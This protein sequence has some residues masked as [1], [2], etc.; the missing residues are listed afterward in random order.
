LGDLGF[1][2]PKITWCNGRGGRDFTKEMLDRAVAN[3]EW[4][5]IFTVVEVAVLA[6]SC[7]D[8]NPLLVSF[9]HT[10]D[11]V[12]QKNKIFRYEAAWSK[13]PEQK[14][15]IKKVWRPKNDNENSWMNIQGNLKG[16]RKSLKKW[17]WRQKI[18]VEL[19]IEA[20]MKEL[21]SIHMSDKSDVLVEENR[22]KEELHVMLEQEEHKWKQ[23]AKINWLQNGDRNTK[24]FNA[25]ANQRKKRNQISK[26]IDKDGRLCSSK[27]DIEEA[28]ISFRKELFTASQQREVKAYT[29]SLDQ[30]VSPQPKIVV[31]LYSRGDLSSFVSNVTSE[32]SRAR[33]ILS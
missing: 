3:A 6:N 33:R 5:S 16:C 12:W 1:V 31:L 4:C 27:E 14:E 8:R 10:N 15:I 26:I 11:V 28:F 23:R 13:H 32:G 29:I 24:F 21:L 2:G 17:V 30:K 22:I 19:Q 18:P 9:S 20:K 7:S 25:Y